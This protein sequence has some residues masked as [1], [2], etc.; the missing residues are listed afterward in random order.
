LGVAAGIALT[1]AA[2][3]VTRLAGNA[4]GRT[5]LPRTE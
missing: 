4:G 2:V 1:A 5:T 3:S